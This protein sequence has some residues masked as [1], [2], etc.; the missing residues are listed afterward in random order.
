MDLRFADG[1]FWQT[2]ELLYAFQLYQVGYLEAAREHFQ[3]LAQEEA[4]RELASYYLVLINDALAGPAGGGWTLNLP[5]G[6]PALWEVDWLHEIFGTSV[7][8][9][10]IDDRSAPPADRSII[11]DSGLNPEKEAYFRRNFELGI[12]QVL[13]HLG[14]EQYFDSCSSYRWC[15]RVYRNLWSPILANVGH[16]TFFPLGYKTGFAQ[17]GGP[18]RPAAARPYVWSFVGDPNKST[19]PEMLNH[20][21]NVAGGFE[22]LISGWD[23]ADS[24]STEAYRAV[25][26]QSVFSPCP[27]GNS[28]LDSFRVYESLEA[29][30]IPIV[31]DR[32]G[33]RYFD[34]LL[35]GHPMPTISN[36]A[37]G[38]AL[39]EDA[40][41][42]GGCERLRQACSAWWVGHKH[43][44]IAQIH[45]DLLA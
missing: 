38:R 8:A 5:A 44:M 41:A 12:R 17:A 40:V 9:E 23:S 2:P 45:A 32:P 1:P 7:T 28:N 43:H 29:G 34:R 30:C 33:Y 24:L 42:R 4:H 27:A 11:V 16:V 10:V 25:L 20:M 3:R 15:R 37:E 18:Q 21:R 6:G 22:H 13:I 14:D 35:P 36:W 19:R 26:D 39:V 31:E